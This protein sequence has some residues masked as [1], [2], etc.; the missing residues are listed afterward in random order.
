[1]VM[2]FKNLTIGFFKGPWATGH[3]A[4]DGAVMGFADLEF[5]VKHAL[6]E[7]ALRRVRTIELDIGLFLAADAGRALKGLDA[8]YANCGPLAVLLFYFREI[9]D[10]HFSIIREVRT[11]GWVGYA[12]QEYIAAG[13]QRDGDLCTHTSAYS[14]DVWAGCREPGND[15]HHYPMLR[16]DRPTRH[17]SVS[18]PPRRCGYFSRLAPDKGFQYIPDILEKLRGAGW[19]IVSLDICGSVA[20]RLCVEETLRRLGRG[21]LRVRLHGAMSHR[22]CLELMAG[23]DVVLFPSVSSVEASGRVVMEAYGLGKTVIASDYCSAHDML[24]SGFRIPFA[25]EAPVTTDSCSAFPVGSLDLEGWQAPEPASPNFHHPSCE[26]YR[27]DPAV[28]REVVCGLPF[29]SGAGGG[30][31]PLHMEILWGEYGGATRLE[32]CARIHG[33]LL[34]LTKHRMD[35]LDL[36]GAMKRAIMLSGFRPQVNFQRNPSLEVGS[37]TIGGRYRYYPMNR[38]KRPSAANL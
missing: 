34:M 18:T 17:R 14:R 12:F 3:T 10:L 26:A 21:P 30:A 36:G 16:G 24:T 27:Y 32:W 6:A 7:P 5:A 38:T 15:L 23:I 25:T 35:L 29:T 31:P 8:V 33:N 20:D 22:R 13:L 1:M 9:H 2:R 19:P 4:R 11:L 28:T 37:K